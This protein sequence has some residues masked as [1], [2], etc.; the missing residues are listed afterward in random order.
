M[1]KQDI[2]MKI[3]DSNLSK[4]AGIFLYFLLTVF[5]TKKE[6][7]SKNVHIQKTLNSNFFK[8]T[9]EELKNKGRKNKKTKI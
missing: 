9:N 4:F 6:R 7:S 2:K 1:K 5:Y 3:K 8:L